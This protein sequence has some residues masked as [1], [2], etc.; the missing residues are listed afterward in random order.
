MENPCA[1]EKCKKR[2]KKEK[3]KKDHLVSTSKSA[4]K[5]FTRTLTNCSGNTANTV[6]QNILSSIPSVLN[7]QI[8]MKIAS[9][10]FISDNNFTIKSPLALCLFRC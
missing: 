7:P 9:F 5:I 1:Y 8:S 3:M 6:T 2:K 4:N 10:L